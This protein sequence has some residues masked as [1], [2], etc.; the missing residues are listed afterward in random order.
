MELKEKRNT[1]M[2]EAGPT[3]GVGL[4]EERGAGWG[5]EATRLHKVQKAAVC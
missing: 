1:P 4:R 2:E 5:V 3:E